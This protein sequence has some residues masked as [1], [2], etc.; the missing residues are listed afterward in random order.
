M[1][2]AQAIT[3]RSQSRFDAGLVVE[4]DLL[5]A[6][7]RLA[8][9]QQELIRVRNDLELAR[10]QLNLAMGMPAESSFQLTE[11][12]AE[13]A[14][15]VQVLA[16]V[17][18]QALTNRPDLKRVSAEEAAQH[19][20]VAIAK[21]SFGP[22]VNAFAGW[23]QDNPTFVAGGG[24]NNWLGGIEL[25]VDIFQGGAKRAEVSRQRARRKGSRI[26][27]SRHGGRPLGSPACLLRRGCQ[28][29]AG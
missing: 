11:S 17:E 10:V 22:R 20:S 6:K 12:L 7:V 25:Q 2:T 18:K 8:S 9:R 29:P 19:Q 16:E 4:S 24:A 13:R 3:E 15:P 21:S 5:T 1:K 23:E 27:A 14:L 28:P 26:E